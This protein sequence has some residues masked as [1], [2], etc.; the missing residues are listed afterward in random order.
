MTAV[1]ETRLTPAE[2]AICTAIAARRGQLVELLQTL[3]GF[4]TTTHTPGAPPRQEASLQTFLADRLQRAGARVEIGVPS[5]DLVAGH[6]MIPAG[7]DFAGRPQLVARFPGS[8]GGRTL[9]LNGHVDTVDVEPVGEWRHDPYAGDVVDDAVHGRGACDMKGGIASMVVAA[10]T[11]ATADIELAGALIVNTVTDEEST[12]AGGL[13]SA[14]TLTADA[15]IVP[16]PTR[17]AV[18][19]ACRGSLLATITIPGRAGHAAIPDAVEPYGTVNAIE[20][21]DLVLAAIRRLRERWRLRPAHPYLAAP[22][23][24]PTEIHGGEWMVTRPASC[25]LSCHL[26]F[27]PDQA[28]DHGWGTLV[29]QEFTEVIRAAAADDPWLAAHPPTVEWTL[30]GVPPAQVEPGH[31]IV[32][33]AGSALVAVGRPRA[34][35]GFDNWHDGATLTVEGGI[36]AICLGPGDV[37]LAHTTGEHVPIADLVSAAQAIAVTAMRFCGTA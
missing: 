37:R 7:F 18:G 4:E 34:I 32:A 22:D 20:K 25:R 26:Q 14:K 19:V 29:Q 2:R 28:D 17:L 24:V 27:L 8:G 33:A 21:V 9:L 11:L 36:P 31:P 23:C 13:V 1:P 16:E 3:V 10:E 5:A 35:T 15:A 30:A 6:P 12:G